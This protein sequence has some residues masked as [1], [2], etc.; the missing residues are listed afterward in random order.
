MANY[1]Y[2]DIYECIVIG[3]GAAGLFYA[4]SDKQKSGA[5]KIIL[6]KTNRPG[7]KLLMSGSGMCNITHGGSI[8]DFVDKYG[9]N[10]PSIRRCLF[11][12]NNIALKK[13]MEAL[14]VPL[15]E[16]DDGKIFPTSLKAADVRDTLMNAA[17]SNGWELRCNAEVSRLELP[18]PDDKIKL[19]LPEPNDISKLELQEL[20]RLIK[21]TLTDGTVLETRKLVIAT[22]GASYPSTG[23]DGSFFDVLHRDLNLKIIEPRPALAPVY[24]Q[25]FKFGH[26]AGISLEEVEVNCT[27]SSTKSEMR[28]TNTKNL[29]KKSLTHQRRGPMLFTHRG[30]SG[31]AMLHIS[32]FVHPGST[33]R[34]NYLP[35]M[36]SE[37]V[38]DI[39]RQDHQGNN[40]SIAN[41]LTSR[42]DLPKA[43]TTA[44]VIE[45]SIT[46]SKVSQ[47][48]HK[49]LRTI[50]ETLTNHSF[51][52]SGT[53]GW[54]DA[55]VTAGGVSLDQI[56]LKTM[57]VR[58]SAVNDPQ[59]NHPVT[60]YNAQTNHPVTSY[61][62]RVIGEALDV[63]GN[64]G[65]YNLQFAYSS[66]MAALEEL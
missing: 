57:S 46:K 32:Q 28:S 6:E 11:K 22:G 59:T 47:L 60:S 48:S 34:I 64:T 54:N 2:E 20:N 10:G 5:A 27:M 13:T 26:L 62:I 43:F 41:Y 53:G 38:F 49:D 9:D 18:E 1:K 29:T 63:N 37:K 17:R 45:M 42:F 30:F 21:I 16:R 24:V 14:G 39:L 3:A 56:D 52:V 61:D 66:A 33:L 40:K 15:L 55:M 7:Q 23:S 36:N 8:K 58:L 51:S 50:A 4:A 25:E 35:E 31:P 44:L 65:G 12:N 19:E